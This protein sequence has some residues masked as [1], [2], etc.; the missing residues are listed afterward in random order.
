MKP[1]K[2]PRE[3]VQLSVPWAEYRALQD[4]YDS[5]VREVLAMKRDGFVPPLPEGVA[6]QAPSLPSEVSNAIA[7]LVDG[8][9]GD[10]DLEPTLTAR[11]WHLLR[12]GLAE[13]A[14]AA[15]IR[16]GEPVD[17]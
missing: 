16:E 1:A 10:S 14:V 11:A 9:A 2:T 4:K 15:R 6:M 7:E 8:A 5:L 13:D 17:L 3:L 12:N